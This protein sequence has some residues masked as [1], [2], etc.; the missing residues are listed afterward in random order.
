LLPAVLAASLLA[1]AFAQGLSELRLGHKVVAAVL[2][3][4]VVVLPPV[5][6]QSMTASKFMMYEPVR[7]KHPRF[8]PAEYRKHQNDARYERLE[9]TMN[10]QA[11]R[12]RLINATARDDFL[13]KDV[14]QVPRARALSD[15][16]VEYGEVLGITR[17]G[18]ARYR[19]D[20]R[21]TE[22]S[23][24]WLN[25]FW[26][27]GWRARID[28]REARTAAVTKQGLVGVRMSAGEHRVEFAFG[29]TTLRQVAWAL[30]ALGVSLWAAAVIV[31]RWVWRGTAL[32]AK[33]AAS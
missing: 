7:Q 27:G 30:T 24:V 12:D 11:M 33:S 3:L 31:F 18:Y 28:G 10:A 22:E 19:A 13:P 29:S 4:A 9:K 8:T 6:Y 2:A 21:L 1:A 32:S 17:T 14:Q 5:V 15:V 16:T 25:R 23:V 26:F 20:V